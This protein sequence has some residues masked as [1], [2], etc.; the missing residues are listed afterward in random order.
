MVVNLQFF[1]GRGSKSGIVDIT[2]MSNSS[3]DKLENT[4]RQK[5][6]SLKRKMEEIVNK[7]GNAGDGMPRSYYSTKQKM[8]ESRQKLNEILDEKRRRKP[9]ESGSRKTFVNSY[10]EATKRDVSTSGYKK[11]QKELGNRMRKL[12]GV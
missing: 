6:E 3:L 11:S 12:I 4:Y 10:G 5:T 2:K 8:N 9:K 1:G 7:D